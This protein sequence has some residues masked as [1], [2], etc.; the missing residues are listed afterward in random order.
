MASQQRSRNALQLTRHTV[1]GFR[2]QV[3]MITKGRA[4]LV[5]VVEWMYQG[6]P[7]V[8]TYF[9]SS[10]YSRADYKRKFNNEQRSLLERGAPFKEYDISLLYIILQLMCGLTGPNDPSWTSPPA[11][12]PLEHL[13]YKVKQKRNNIA[14]TNDV[15]QM[16]DQKLAK[17]LKELGRL[18][19]RI[20]RL[21]GHRCGIRPHVFR[22]EIWGIKQDFRDLFSKV[23]EPLQ[24]SDLDKLPQLQQ[25]IRV[26]QEALRQSV[27]QESRRELHDFYPLLWDVTL[28]Q[29]LYPDLKIRPSLN[30]TNL[31]IIEDTSTMTPSQEQNY[32]PCDISHENLLQVAPRSGRLPEVIIISGEGGIGK[33]TLLKHMLEMW[34]RDPSQIKG[35]RD[36]SPLLYLQLRGCTISCWEDMLKHLLHSTFQ[37]SGLTIDIFADLFQAMQ[38][39]V[40][41]DG[42]DEVSKKAKKL[43]TDLLNY[44]GSMRIVITTRPGCVKELTQIMKSKKHVMNVQIK[45]IRRE[46]RSYFIE[47]TLAAFVQCSIQR[48]NLQDKLVNTLENLEFEKDGLDV[49]LTLILLIIREV[50]APDQSSQDIFE[51]LTKLMVGKVEERLTLKGIDDAD[52][53]VKEYHEFQ[54]KVALKCLK[55]K[56]HDLLS[57]T[58]ENLKEKCT[59]LNLPYK[60]MLSGFLVSKKSRQGLFITFIWSFPH[61][62]FQEHWAAGY[63]VVQLLRMSPSLPDLTGLLDSS[64]LP[65]FNDR[66]RLWSFNRKNDIQ[67]DFTENPILEIYENDVNEARELSYSRTSRS[68]SDILMEVL[69]NI[70]RTL[71]LS[72]KSLL[73]KVAIA[74]ISLILYGDSI[75]V[76]GNDECERYY[77]MVMVSGRHAGIVEASARVLRETDTLIVKET[78]LPGLL[79]MLD[80]TKTRCVSI[81][82]TNETPDYP[83][84]KVISAM[85]DLSRRDIEIVIKSFQK[86]SVEFSEMCLEAI[87]GPGSRS[88]LTQFEGYLAA[89]GML[90][91]PESLKELRTRSDVGGM[92]TLVARLPYLQNL[93]SLDFG[94]RLTAAEMPLLPAV[95]EELT[96]TTDGEGLEA[97]A[98][99]L[100]HLRNLRLLDFEGQLTE[101]EMPFLPCN[102]KQALIETDGQGLRALAR[103]LPQ[104]KALYELDLTL[105][106][107]PAPASLPILPYEG[108]NLTLNLMTAAPPSCHWVCDAVQVLCSTRI[109][110]TR[111]VLP[112]DYD[113]DQV[114]SLKQELIERGATFLRHAKGLKFHFQGELKPFD[115]L[116]VPPLWPD[117]PSPRRSCYFA[118]AA[119]VPLLA[120]LLL[121][122]FP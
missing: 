62:R 110:T 18:F 57:E 36:V 70:T 118:L 9:L 107:C 42:Y 83:S 117:R 75:Y 63:V 96:V 94:G 7:C 50:V 119:L 113:E 108:P 120:W 76:M 45:G 66:E 39:V 34:V 116:D 69:I 105:L 78:L 77:R 31:V 95:L 99:R 71:A 52:D 48:A 32:Q 13:L 22:D 27:Q 8:K 65:K 104:L 47:N 44:R 33:T 106:D 109:R 89:A 90:L 84:R 21:A 81:Y 73:D 85:R 121:G 25:E 102:L 15:Q 59:T 114:R 92:Q 38:V 111:L 72:K 23:R 87:T 54:K 64:C 88:R 16:S 5:R 79:P 26:F 97:L 35:L 12:Q 115:P 14:H 122:M 58:V 41:L 1:N 103:R 19:S 2:Y 91:L 112:L 67:L 3:A 11:G 60:E 53:K 56:E 29:W 49:P 100:P 61:N 86:Q 55:R 40:L 46:D 4:V 98:R 51:D 68:K 93:Q 24:A 6:G 20:L 28:A 37:G 74:I 30:F 43:I 101:E 82:I 80:H 10:G 17:E